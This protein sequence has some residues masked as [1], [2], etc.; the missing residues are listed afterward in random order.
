MN[1]E[2]EKVKKVL[3]TSGKNEKFSHN[4]QKRKTIKSQI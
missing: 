4:A 1:T 2:L 3:N